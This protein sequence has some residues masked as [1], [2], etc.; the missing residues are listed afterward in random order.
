[1]NWE[2]PMLGRHH[3]GDAA[4]VIGP[5]SLCAGGRRERLCA[6]MTAVGWALG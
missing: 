1:M 6:M 5:W 3:G 2:R 4:V